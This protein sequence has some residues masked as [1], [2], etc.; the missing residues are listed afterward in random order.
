MAPA[1]A[2]LD[3]LNVHSVDGVDVRRDV[4]G[5]VAQSPAKITQLQ[6]REPAGEPIF[7]GQD[8]TGWHTPGNK[9]AWHVE[10]GAIVKRGGG[11]N[12]LKTEKEYGNF[13]L[14]RLQDEPREQ[15]RH[16]HSHAEKR[17]AIGRWHGTATA[18]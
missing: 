10:N 16:R 12:Y 5:I 7:N 13:T 15:F 9:D 2:F 6:F 3:R 18:G 11:G 1:T 17:L 14:S 8:L 4:L